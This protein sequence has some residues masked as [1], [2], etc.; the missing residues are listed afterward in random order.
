[1]KPR[2][3]KT[4]RPSHPEI[5]RL[6]ETNLALRRTLQ[7]MEEA[8]AQ[9]VD[10]YD[11]A[12][13]G[14]VTL[15]A[16]GC[17]REVNLT[18]ARMLGRERSRLLTMPFFTQVAKPAV[19]AFLNHLR[20]C[21][22]QQAEV[23]SEVSLRAGRGGAALPVELRSGPV[24]D[25]RGATVYRTTITDISARLRADRALRE[26]EE[27]HRE[28]VE[29]SPDGIFIESDGVIVFANGTAQRLCGVGG[30][31]ALA[32]TEFNAWVRPVFRAAVQ[33]A[34]RAGESPL[35][36][37]QLAQRGGGT[38]EVELLAR[39]FR[40]E[41]EACV[42]IV[43]RDISRRRQA[44]R[45]VLAISERERT[46]FGQDVHDSL[47]QSLM[48]AAYLADNLR[49]RTRRTSRA[50]AADA[51]QISDVVR[52][53]AEEAR[54]L[55][56]GLCPA[57]ME[58]SGL[59]AALHQLSADVTQRSR[60]RCA[61]ECDDRLTVHDAGVATHLYRIAQ[62]AVANAIKHGRA[63]SVQI[64][65]VAGEGAMTLRVRDDGKGS[66]A[67][68]KQSGM[69]LHTMQYRATMIG[70][71]L[72]VRRTRPRGTLVSCCFPA[73]NGATP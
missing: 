48:G 49:K 10:Q 11:F 65:L 1:M 54:G 35:I 31:G 67:K 27:R 2:A 14:F 68:T 62:E 18:A 52:Q 59:V 36:E 19:P 53:C 13:L 33:D 8:R 50:V 38:V 44:E 72:D 17:I 16:K 6:E 26:S 60:V 41:G 28:M 40:H 15:D 9:L 58:S 4:P 7:I 69:G 47:C 25:L 43:A 34:L 24:P 71:S 66:S 46:T 55:A 37:A 20:E 12:P 56:R 5:A 42:L 70:G 51:G 73:S 29:H 32:G 30:M 64:Q 45:Q 21:R 3:P 39:R 57:A 23:I 61:V 63:K 22:G